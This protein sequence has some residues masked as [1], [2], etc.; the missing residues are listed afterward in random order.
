MIKALSID[1]RTAFELTWPDD[2][3][4][5]DFLLWVQYD[6][7]LARVAWWVEPQGWWRRYRWRSH[8]MAAALGTALGQV[9]AEQDRQRQRADATDVA[10]QE[11]QEIM[12]I[13]Q[14]LDA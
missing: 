11:A 7:P 10:L 1:A 3:P 2:D 13:L 9:R 14:E 5:G 12:G 6:G 4:Q 8:E